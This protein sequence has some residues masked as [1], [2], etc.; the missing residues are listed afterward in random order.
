MK[1]VVLS[2]ALAAAALAGPAAGAECRLD[3]L[4]ELPITMEGLRP[5]VP[6]KINGTDV[7]LI[8]DS[9]A[10]FSSLTPAA[11]ARLN[12]KVGPLPPNM[13]VRGMTGTADVGLTSVKDFGVLGGAF[14]NTQFLVGGSRIAGAD[15]MLGRNFLTMVD[16]E[17]DLANGAIRLFKPSGCGARP[18]AYWSGDKPYS[19]LDADPREG[20]QK[21]IVVSASV[22]GARI[23]VALD[24]GSPRSILS[25]AAARRAGV[26]LSTPGIQPAGNVGGLGRRVVDSWIA[27]F[28]SFKIGDEEVRGTRL[29]IGDIDLGGNADMLL[30]ADFFMSHRIYVSAAQ[31]RVYFTY[32]GGPVFQLDRLGPSGP[33]PAQ[34]AEGAPKTEGAPS[35]E[36]LARSAAGHAT[37]G[38]LELALADFDQAIRLDPSS[39]KLHYDRSQVRLRMRRPE[40]ALEDVDAALK[41]DPHYAPALLSRA[42]A[43]LARR[44]EEGARTDL[45]AALAAD[46]DSA[47]R[48]AALWID[49]GRFDLAVSLLDRWIGDH[50]RDDRLPDALNQRCRARALWNRDLQAA[51]ADCNRSLRDGR[52]AQ[53]RISR[54]LVRLRLGQNREAIEDF[55]AAL[56][57]RADAPWALYGRGVAKLKSGDKPGG[58]ADLQAAAAVAPRLAETA[59]NIGIAP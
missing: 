49:R 30:G 12:L 58:D 25:L 44:N 59:R 38:E 31:D 9:G 54:G 47:P 52:V 14:H 46:P 28:A 56:K 39:A 13:F 27:P 29:R 50:P 23:R 43:R 8:T 21:A 41:L 3:K 22:N 20:P 26:D 2:A 16:A 19:M 35:A 11:A 6:A 37:R 17:F 18:L 40:L 45:D 55:D 57:D 33:P 15:G 4:A 53:F 51:L 24:T 32:N 42:A 48:I 7:R 34:L 5:M 1:V 36:A 10:F